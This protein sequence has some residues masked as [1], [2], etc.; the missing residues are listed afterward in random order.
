MAIFLAMMSSESGGPDGPSRRSD[1]SV[2][3]AKRFYLEWLLSQPKPDSPSAGP[4]S[5]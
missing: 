2:C 4:R 5:L 3:P 1:W